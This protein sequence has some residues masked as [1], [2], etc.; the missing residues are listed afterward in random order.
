ML[1]LRS[2]ILSKSMQ[3]SEMISKYSQAQL[4]LKEDFFNEFTEEFL[5]K[6]RNAF[7]LVFRLLH[8]IFIGHQG[9]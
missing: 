9:N 7:P 1:H 5:K 8:F 4:E 3:R 6:T 2:G